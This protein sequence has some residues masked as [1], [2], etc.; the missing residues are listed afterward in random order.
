MKCR[1][2]PSNRAPRS[3]PCS[4]NLS[5]NTTQKHPEAAGAIGEISD[6]AQQGAR[7]RKVA[8]RTRYRKP[9]LRP[10]HTRCPVC[11]RHKARRPPRPDGNVTR[12]SLG[13]RL[14]FALFVLMCAVGAAAI[15]DTGPFPLNYAF[16]A[17]AII[18][19]FAIVIKRQRSLDK[20]KHN[21]SMGRV[22]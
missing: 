19:P 18:L 7:S 17:V 14:H 12:V 21:D 6:Q 22:S 13:T 3:P 11:S 9:R 8:Y 16:G 4:Q 20:A 15:V 5:Q 10:A 2:R 1:L